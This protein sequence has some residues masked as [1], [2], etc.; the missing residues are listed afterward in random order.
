MVAA[1]AAAADMA[2]GSVAIGLQRPAAA[3]VAVP[4]YQVRRSPSS[5]TG[6]PSWYIV[7][8]ASPPRTSNANQRK[9]HMP[10]RHDCVE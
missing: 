7:Y 9:L 1:A 2:V 6:C 10:V 8:M 3:V 4:C 5:C